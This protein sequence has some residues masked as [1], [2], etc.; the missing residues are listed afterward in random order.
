MKTDSAAAEGAALDAGILPG[1]DGAQAPGAILAPAP[2]A[3]PAKEWSEIPAGVGAMLAFQFPELREVYTEGACMA[4]GTAMV[5]IAA[6]YGWTPG[7]FFP[8]FSL[9]GATASLLVPTMQVI[10]AHAQKDDPAPGAEKPLAS[11]TPIRAAPAPSGDPE[12]RDPTEGNPPPRP[13]T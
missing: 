6:R 3:D 4:W 8:W 2:V 10:K 5:P 9:I 13:V 12:L 11:V 1:S 7:K